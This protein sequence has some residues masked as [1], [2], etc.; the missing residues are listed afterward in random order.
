MSINTAQRKS[1]AVLTGRLLEEDTLDK[2][3]DKITTKNDISLK[4][5]QINIKTFPMMIVKTTKNGAMDVT[6]IANTVTMKTSNNY[7]SHG[8]H[9]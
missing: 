3:N 5:N 6:N 4:N 1:D 9:K 7:T 2:G 8:S